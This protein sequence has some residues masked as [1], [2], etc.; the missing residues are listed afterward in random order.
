MI[1]AHDMGR[2]QTPVYFT[3]NKGNQGQGLGGVYTTIPSKK[4]LLCGEFVEEVVK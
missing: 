2:W 4:C 3:V 1:C